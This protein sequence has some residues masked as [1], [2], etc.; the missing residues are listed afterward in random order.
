MAKKKSTRIIAIS[1]CFFNGVSALFGGGSLIYDP[2]GKFL[3]MPIEF[4]EHTPF[5]NFL[6]PGIILF[7][8]NGLFNVLVGILGIRKNSL[9]PWLTTLCGLLLTTWLTVQIIMIQQFYAPAHVTYYLAGI[10][11]IVTGLQLSIQAKK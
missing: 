11:L 7:T 8:V 10:L 6:I 4:L 1:L 9:F 3:Q 2:T 5:K